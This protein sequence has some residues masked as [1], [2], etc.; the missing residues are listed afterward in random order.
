MPKHYKIAVV[1]GSP[2]ELDGK[3]LLLKTLHTC[4]LEINVALTWKPCLYW[5]PQGWKVDVTR[6]EPRSQLTTCLPRYIH[7]CDTI[8]MLQK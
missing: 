5:P 4:I 3:T 8:W 2:S 6:R 1:P 7:W